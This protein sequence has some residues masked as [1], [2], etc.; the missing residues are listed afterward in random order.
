L[1]RS[2]LIDE[3]N[4]QALI[5]RHEKKIFAFTLYLTGGDR[6]KAYDLAVSGCAESW[7]RLPGPKKE[8]HFLAGAARAIVEKIRA[9]QVISSFYEGD[10]EKLPAAERSALRLVHA[11]LQ[12]LE[13]EDKAYILLRDQMNLRYAEIAEVFH[14]SEAAARN[15][16]AQAR[17]ALRKQMEDVL[18]RAR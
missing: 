2:F 16:T 18:R 17:A 13:F 4:L 6:D 12:S 11:A 15:G 8:E 9:S 1:K 7:Q 5:L 10:F 14:A 3:E